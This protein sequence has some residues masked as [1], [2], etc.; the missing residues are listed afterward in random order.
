[1]AETVFVLCGLASLACA[2][3]LW[4]GYLR[5]RTRLL[6]WSSL[7]FVGLGI[8]NGLLVVDKIV[9]PEIDLSS[10]RSLAALAGLLLLLYGLIWDSE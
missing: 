6:L 5:H 10:I 9:Y 3:L 1:M 7:C 8:N 2:I 4:R